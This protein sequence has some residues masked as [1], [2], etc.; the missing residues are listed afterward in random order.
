MSFMVLIAWTKQIDIESLLCVYLELIEF[1]TYIFSIG[2]DVTHGRKTWP[3]T[4][5][6]D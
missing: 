2:F 1:C 5:K 6:F 4:C 3:N